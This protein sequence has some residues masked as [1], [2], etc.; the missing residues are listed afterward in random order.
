[1]IG[2]FR[3]FRMESTRNAFVEFVP[4]LIAGLADAEEPDNA[5]TAFDRFLQ[6][7]QRGGRL[8]SLLSQNRDSSRW[9]RSSWARRPGSATCWR[10]SRRS[11]TA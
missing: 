6:A 1:M 9:W 2:D 7:L 5:V 3:V 11:W 10:G 4:A 8:I